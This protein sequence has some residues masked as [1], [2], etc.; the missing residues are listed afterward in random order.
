MFLKI[1]QTDRKNSKC[2]RFTISESLRVSKWIRINTVINTITIGCWA[3]DAPSVLVPLTRHLIWWWVVQMLW[4]VL[5]ICDLKGHLQV[6]LDKNSWR[7]LGWSLLLISKVCSKSVTFCWNM[8][9]LPVI[10]FNIQFVCVMD[11]LSHTSKI[12]VV[13]VLIHRIRG[14]W[15]C[16]YDILL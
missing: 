16:T 12:S 14:E 3:A 11:E 15:N 13:L 9:S 2:F 5:Q 7:P 6:N 8:P 10:G 1:F 4:A